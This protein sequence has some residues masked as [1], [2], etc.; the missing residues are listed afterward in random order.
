MTSILAQGASDAPQP[1]QQTAS[2]QS[3]P[4]GAGNPDELARSRVAIEGVWPQVDGGRFPVK[5]AVGDL[6]VVEA[7]IFADGHDK[8]DAALLYKRNGEHDWREAPMRLVDNDR[9]RGAFNLSE[10]ARYHYTIIAWRDLFA[11]WRDEVAKKHAAGVSIGVEL[12]EGRLLIEQAA[13]DDTRGGEADRRAL[14]TAFA[15]ARRCDP[16]GPTAR[17][18]TLLDSRSAE[19]RALVVEAVLSLPLRRL[20]LPLLPALRRRYHRDA[21]LSDW[22]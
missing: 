18:E 10:N 9:W 7:D 16:G 15:L 19:R 14:R 20:F 3:P 12:T 6:L 4:A 13:T 17:L 22:R 2:C 11:S 1:R 21:A 8:I 5:R